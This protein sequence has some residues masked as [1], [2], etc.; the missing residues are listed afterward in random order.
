MKPRYT[1][2]ALTAITLPIGSR[3]LVG[4]VDEAGR[5]DP[6]VPI[7]ARGYSCGDAWADARCRHCPARSEIGQLGAGA[8]TLVVHRD[9]CPGLA[10]IRAELD[11]TGPGPMRPMDV[12]A[13]EEL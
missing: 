8:L 5:D 2:G 13:G 7:P 6:Q 10:A 9:G 3:L 12:D 4:H 1:D 11:D